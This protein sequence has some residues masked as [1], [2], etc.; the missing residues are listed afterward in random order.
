[1]KVLVNAISLRVAGG[2][3][4]ALNFLRALGQVGS[5]HTYY[6]LAP[7]NA[8]YEQLGSES[9]IIRVLPKNL[10]SLPARFLVD[11]YWVPR[12]VRDLRPD[13]IFSMGN[14]A[15]PVRHKQLVL[16]HHPYAI[17]DDAEVWS[18]M[19][20]RHRLYRRAWLKAFELSLPYASEIVTQTVTAKRRLEKRY[21][22]DPQRVRVVPNAVSIAQPVAAS[23]GL[24]SLPERR[25][26][27]RHLLCL[28]RYYVHKNVEVFLRVAELIR[29]RKMGIRIITTIARDQ[30]SGAA[31]FLKEIGDRRL[32]DIIVNIGPVAMADIPALYRAVDGMILPTLLESFSGTYVEAMYYG[33][34]V[35]TSDRDFARD[36]CGDAAYYF[37]PLDPEAILETVERALSDPQEMRRRVARGEEIVSAMPDWIEVARQYV[38]L[39][40]E[41]AYG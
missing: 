25:P 31:A 24:P 20:W 15:L 32:H 13:V 5:G 2:R 33:V 30:G 36:V 35:F 23:P 19:N 34:P 41:L 8:G 9:V 3:S 6:V 12:L 14:I 37:D 10:S 29:A 28:T 1:M 39:L 11:Y 16:F 38:A 17:Y 40:E 4:V 22:L 26:G 18:R 21:A 27:E 7:R